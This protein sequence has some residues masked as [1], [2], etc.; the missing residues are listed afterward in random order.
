M[1]ALCMLGG[2][3]LMNKN[4]IWAKR[5]RVCVLTLVRKDKVG[6]STNHQVGRNRL[7]NKRSNAWPW[8]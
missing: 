1:K 6:L 5:E 4:V 3:L 8:R 2:R 7:N